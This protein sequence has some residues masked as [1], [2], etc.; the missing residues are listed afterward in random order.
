MIC[1]TGGRGACRRECV[2]YEVK[3]GDCDSVYIG[4]T[5]RNAYTRGLEHT[6]N[7][8]KKDNNSGLYKHY[9]QAHNNKEPQ[10]TMTVTGTY[11][12]AL[13]R[14]ISEAVKINSVP[15][16]SNRLNNKEEWGRSRIPRASL[17]VE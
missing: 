8:R 13:T 7:L 16:I 9:K 1:G 5:A 3:C 6:A 14:Q 10:Y 4:E 12:D 11:S 2:T 15:E 17:T